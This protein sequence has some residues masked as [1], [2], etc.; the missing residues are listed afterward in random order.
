MTESTR[1]DGCVVK[2]AVISILSVSW[3]KNIYAVVTMVT[4]FVA[5]RMREPV[6]RRTGG[7]EERRFQKERA[8]ITLCLPA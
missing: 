7:K 8:N 3:E 1:T 5:A 6:S 2:G 4:K